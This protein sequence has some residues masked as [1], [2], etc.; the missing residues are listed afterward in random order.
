MSQLR[1]KIERL[2]KRD[3]PGMGF[4]H[5]ARQQA[6]AMLLGVLGGDAKETR[7]AFDAGADFAV[8]RADGSR[9]A[10]QT[11]KQLAGEG[12]CLGAWL[13][14]LSADDSETLREAGC[15]FTISSFEGTASVAVDP[16]RMGH[17]LQVPTEGVED[18]ILRALAPLGLDALL[19]EGE[20]TGLS[21]ASQLQ[22]VRLSAFSGTPLIV[23]VS[24]EPSP[25]ELRTLRDSGC[26]AIIL[27]EDAAPSRVSALLETLKAV[28]PPRKAKR[29]GPDV[30]IVPATGASNEHEDDGG[31]DDD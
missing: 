11:V 1:K 4:A 29:E 20:A 18:S 15:D 28:P 8:V 17:V 23:T 25:A 13:P 16:D 7:S 5:V 24:G 19:F 12:A 6:A 22:L 2:Q 27:V 10:A 26:A 9:S 3:G 21:L 14:S 31:D 30:A